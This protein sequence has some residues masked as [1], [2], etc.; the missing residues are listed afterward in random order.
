MKKSVHQ[1]V[2]ICLTTSI[3]LVVILFGLSKNMVNTGYSF[4]RQFPPHPIKA[5]DTLDLEFDSYYIAGG[6]PYHFYL[7][8]TTAS[9]H[10]LLLNSHLSDTQ[11][12]SFKS[13]EIDTMKFWSLRVKVD[14]PRFILADGTLPAIFTGTVNEWEVRH[15]QHDDDAFFV[16]YVPITSGSIGIRSI[17]SKTGNYVLG[18]KTLHNED[19]TLSYELLEKQLDGRFCVD[20]MLHYSKSLARLIYVYYYRNQFIVA[21]TSLNLAYRGKTI[22]TISHAQIKIAKLSSDNLNTHAAPP[23][24]VNKQSCVEDDFL[25]INSGLLAKNE[26]K[27]VFDRSSVIDVYDIRNGEYKL[28]FYIP[29]FS[30]KKMHDF[31][32]FGNKLIVLIDTYVLTYTL[33]SRYFNSDGQ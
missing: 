31:R 19:V 32:V 2:F 27:K 18:K 20:G 6:T 17:G 23:L 8:N 21:D 4:L 28:S 33:S 29:E 5:G 25:F 24:F 1:T 10:L 12:I 22:D 3:A 16:D 26:E 30:G 14:S 7:G 15:T 9:L 11:H 13:H